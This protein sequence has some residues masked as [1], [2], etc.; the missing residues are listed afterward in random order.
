MLGPFRVNLGQ[1]LFNLGQFYSIWVQSGTVVGKQIET[2]F[3]G[4]VLVGSN[5]VGPF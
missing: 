5:L 3:V 2:V 4:T 1:F